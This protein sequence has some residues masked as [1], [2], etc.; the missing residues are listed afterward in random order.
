MPTSLTVGKKRVREAEEAAVAT[1]KTKV[2]VGKHLPAASLLPPRPKLT[3][4]AAVAAAQ[5]WYDE[6]GGAAFGFEQGTYVMATPALAAYRNNATE[7]SIAYKTQPD[8][9]SQNFLRFKYKPKFKHGAWKWNL[10]GWGKNASRAAQ[11]LD[12]KDIAV[13]EAIRWYD[14]SGPAAF[15]FAEGALKIKQPVLGA[16][17]N[18]DT[19]W[20][21]KYKTEPDLGAPYFLRV[22][23]EEASDGSWKATVGKLEGA[24]ELPDD[25]KPPEEQVGEGELGK[26]EAIAD[27]VRWY[28]EEGGTAFGFENGKYRIKTPVVAAYRN[29]ATAWSVKYVTEPPLDR[30][31]FVRFT[32]KK[33]A[34]QWKAVDGDL[35][36]ASAL[37]DKVAEPPYASPSTATAQRKLPKAKVPKKT[38]L[39]V[40]CSSTA[41]P[42]S[43]SSSGDGAVSWPGGIKKQEQAQQAP[44]NING[45]QKQPAAAEPEAEPKYRTDSEAEENEAS[46]SDD[47]QRQGC[48]EDDDDGADDDRICRADAISAAVNWYNTKAAAAFNFEP[49]AYQINTGTVKDAFRNDDTDWS[50]KYTTEPPLI[51]PTLGG[52][53]EFF[54]RFS[55]EMKRGRWFARTQKGDASGSKHFDCDEPTLSKE[56]A[57]LI[58]RAHYDQQQLFGPYEMLIAGLKGHRNNSHDW[59]LEFRTHPDSGGPHLLRFKFVAEETRKDWRWKVAH[60][61]AEGASKSED[62]GSKHRSKYS[63]TVRNFAPPGGG[64]TSSSAS[65]DEG[66]DGEYLGGNAKK[67]KEKK[68]NS[69]QIAKPKSDAEHGRPQRKPQ[70]KRGKAGPGPSLKTLD[71]RDRQE[72]AAAA[73]ARPKPV[74][75]TDA[76]KASLEAQE[77]TKEFKKQQRQVE[78]QRAAMREQVGE[79]EQGKGGPERPY[80]LPPDDADKNGYGTT[81]SSCTLNWNDV[82]W[83]KLKK[84][85]TAMVPPAEKDLFGDD[86]DDD[87]AEDDGM[88][89]QWRE[90]AARVAQY[91]E[92]EKSLLQSA[93]QGAAAD[94]RLR[95]VERAEQTAVDA[96]EDNRFADRFANFAPSWG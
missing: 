47:G 2:T 34:N 70:K 61:G 13:A 31:F 22:S 11:G 18:N 76:Q 74:K 42:A 71:E 93:S 43:N 64:D 68:K 58:G 46:D 19:E 35:G 7:W 33:A 96:E 37:P 3:E 4:E 55:Y 48:A 86:S 26:E 59:T 53:Q 25:Y 85:P 82:E 87:D 72:A 79:G 49:G 14:T 67:K 50:V 27:A 66:S 29:S 56:Q 41:K 8:C 81:P 28:Y 38:K 32:Y 69:K 39:T 36:T 95:E 10:A 6:K 83:E 60:F 77:A 73:C 54:V 89:Q 88:T 52:V 92:L 40:G 63:P 12:D 30:E 5:K 65:S 62:V 17:R 51:D 90:T 9:G 20:S 91:R 84:V 44:R 1:K 80:I 75:L 45:V 16:Y 21:V 15:N 94:V 24:S 78:E 23:Y 57:L